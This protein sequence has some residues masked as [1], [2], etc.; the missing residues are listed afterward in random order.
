MLIFDLEVIGNKLYEIRKRTGMTQAEIAEAAGISDRTYADIER[1]T[2]NMRVGTML[3]IC[4]VFH[5]TPNDILTEKA[6]ESIL[7]EK[8]ILREI[9]DLNSKDKNTALALLEVYLQ[10]IK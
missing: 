4:N 10:S 9:S 8:D 6:S 3:Q 1:G 2:A 5:I 7:N